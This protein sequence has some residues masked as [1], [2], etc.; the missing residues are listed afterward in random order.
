MA[1][2]P[3]PDPLDRALE[4]ARHEE[5]QGWIELSASI[6]SRVR[7]TIA[8]S[9]P[10]LAFNQA[11][12]AEHDETGS[13]T[14]VSARIVT[15]A[16]RRALDLPT[17]AP[18]GIDLVIEEE[19]LR[20]VELSLVAA[21]GVDLPALAEV[22]RDRVHEAVVGLLGPDPEFSAASIDVHISDVVVG[23]PHVV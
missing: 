18:D 2:E 1:L 21:Y 4:A 15:A 23:D 22:A 20:R 9:E 3:T 10:I 6:M 17:V 13:R 19:R 11:G 8:P 12:L 7:R 5:P 16:I 14:W